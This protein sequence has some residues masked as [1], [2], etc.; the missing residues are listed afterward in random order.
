MARYL[1]SDYAE[2]PSRGGGEGGRTACKQAK[3]QSPGGSWVGVGAPFPAGAPR[4]ERLEP[5]VHG[6]RSAPATEPAAEQDGDVL[7]YTVAEAARLARV[8]VWSYYRGLKEGRLPGRK[9]RGQWRVS[10]KQ[11]HRFLDGDDITSGGGP[12]VA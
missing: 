11:L 9:V 8:S 7:T 12:D 6:D 3:P 4:H 1:H 5:H 10:R 2:S